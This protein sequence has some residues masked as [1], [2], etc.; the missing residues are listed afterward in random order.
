[1]AQQLVDLGEPVSDRTLTLNL[2]RGL[3]ER[4][5]DAGRHI[6]R[7]NPFLKFKDAVDELILEELTMAHQPPARPTALLAAGKGA[8]SGAPPPSSS[9]ARPHTPPPTA[10]SQW[11]L[12]L[13]GRASRRKS[14][15]CCRR[16][17][18]S[19]SGETPPS[20]SNG[21]SGG[22]KPASA[23]STGSAGGSSWPSFLHPWT[24]AIQ[25]R[26]GPRPTTPLP[27]AP[28]PPQQHQ[29]LLVQQPRCKP[30][31]PSRRKH[32]GRPGLGTAAGA[33]CIGTDGVLSLG[34]RRPVPS[35][36]ADRC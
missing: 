20:S 13:R 24:M 12:Q 15:D 25:L 4:F 3:N 1:M 28:T 9:G 2:I 11:G 35:R 27:A 14:K 19:R 21:Q 5:R 26:P 33:G 32:T 36:L 6:R 23:P 16:G 34:A 30:C 17:G 18:K 7:D 31:W 29:A 10:L 8:P 22:G